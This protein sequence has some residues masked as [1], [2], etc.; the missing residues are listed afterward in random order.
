MR[1]TGPEEE[2][3][4][5]QGSSSLVGGDHKSITLGELCGMIKTLLIMD[6]RRAVN[7][8]MMRSDEDPTIHD[9]ISK[10][11]RGFSNVERVSR[12]ISI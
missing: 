2:D 5:P 6:S 8:E 7:T 10:S 12:G 4:H 11:V 3:P 9:V 1:Y